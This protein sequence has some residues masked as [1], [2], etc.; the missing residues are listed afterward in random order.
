MISKKEKIWFL[1]SHL[2]IFIFISQDLRGIVAAFACLSLGRCVYVAEFRTSPSGLLPNET[3]LSVAPMG[4]V[5][6]PDMSYCQM[7]LEAPVPPTADQVP[8]YCICSACSGQKSQKG[9][10]GDRGLPGTDVLSAHT[11]THTLCLLILNVFIWIVYDRESWQSRSKRTHW[12]SR[13]PRT[14]WTSW[15]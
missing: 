14:N 7:I 10:K 11:Q 9:E 6:E 8:W 12:V 3:D 15:H 13:S 2:Y 1:Y 4:P 5:V